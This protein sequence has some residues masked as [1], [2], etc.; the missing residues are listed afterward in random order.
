M[1]LFLVL[2]IGLVVRNATAACAGD[3]TPALRRTDTP[4]H[5]DG[6]LAEAVWQRAHTVTHFLQVQ[7]VGG[8]RP[9]ERPEVRFLYDATTRLGVI[10]MNA[11][12]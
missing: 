4:P 9:S 8:A 12:C 1:R 3:V 7:P 5:L 11:I 6:A 10:G 2:T